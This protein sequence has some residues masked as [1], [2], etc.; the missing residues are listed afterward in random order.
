MTDR[1]EYLGCPLLEYM[2]LRGGEEN[3]QSMAAELFPVSN[4]S[5]SFKGKNTEKTPYKSVNI[6]KDTLQKASNA[7]Y[8]DIRRNRPHTV[9]NPLNQPS[10]KAN[11]REDPETNSIKD[12]KSTDR[13]KGS[14]REEDNKDVKENNR[15]TDMPQNMINIVAQLRAEGLDELADLI[16]ILGEDIDIESVCAK[17]TEALEKLMPGNSEVSKNKADRFVKLIKWLNECTE[18]IESVL[19]ENAGKF[20][21]LKLML[22]DIIK[23]IQS[24][25]NEAPDLFDNKIIEILRELVQADDKKPKSATGQQAESVCGNDSVIC[26]QEENIAFVDGKSG[27]EKIDIHTEDNFQTASEDGRA[28]ANRADNSVKY[29]NNST[30]AE[31][32]TQ[33]DII[34]Y[35]ASQR[36]METEMPDSW[37]K[38]EITRQAELNPARIIN[39]VISKAKVII[40]G[41]KSEMVMNLKPDNLGRLS[42]KVITEN[43][44][45]IA[46][47]IAENQQV[48]QTLEANMQQLRQSFEERG[49]SVQNFSVSV[50]Q[51]GG[52]SGEKRFIKQGHVKEGSMR[53]KTVGETSVYSS[54]FSDAS[55]IDPYFYEANTINLTA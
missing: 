22:S 4:D 35:D 25:K 24:L 20:E 14:A 38:S 46:E 55:S 12:K 36:N 40:D 11:G 2:I 50:R 54:R 37:F 52:S 21:E 15:N 51:D 48:K 29:F 47:I 39:Q 18:T 9:S 17:F 31:G 8:K 26:S 32:D 28:E 33:A 1:P 10:E 44:L 13:L 34:A 23:D 6:F 43:G 3:M 19:P 7:L 5:I 49:M 30:E 42:L 45:V 27:E 16:G 53:M 41:E